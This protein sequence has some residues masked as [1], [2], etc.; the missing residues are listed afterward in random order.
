MRVLIALGSNKGDRRAFIKKA[1]YAID[2]LEKTRVATISRIMPYEAWGPAIAT[3]LNATAVLETSLHPL[4][5]LQHMQKIEYELH[6]R[7]RP[8]KWGPRTIDL[9]ILLIEDYVIEHPQLKVPHPY[10]TERIFVLEPACQIAPHWVHPTKR[11]T[12]KHLYH[13]LLRSFHTL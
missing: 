8:Y 6:G 13:S 12:I 2:N 5:L 7:E 4:E 9:D 11:R 10:M 1:I 3:F